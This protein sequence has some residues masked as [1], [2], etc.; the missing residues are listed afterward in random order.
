MMGETG[1]RK[2]TYAIQVACQAWSKSHERC[3]V[4]FIPSYRRCKVHKNQ[5]IIKAPPPTMTIVLYSC[6]ISAYR[7][8]SDTTVGVRRMESKNSYRK[9]TNK[10]RSIY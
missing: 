7:H 6:N 4:R 3:H 1:T 8:D 10:T 5:L 2:A 9:Q